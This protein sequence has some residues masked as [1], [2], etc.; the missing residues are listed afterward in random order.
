VKLIAEKTTTISAKNIIISTG[1]K[2]IISPI[3]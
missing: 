1:S 2:P 3:E